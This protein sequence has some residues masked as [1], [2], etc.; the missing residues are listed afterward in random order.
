MK[1]ILAITAASGAIYARQIAERLVADS[2]VEQIDILFSRQ[3]QQVMNY[4]G[5]A[6][7]VSSKICYYDNDD[8]FAPMASGSSSYEA[9]IIAPCSA[10]TMCRIASGLSD[11]LITRAA[12]VM[13][14]EQRKLLLLLRESP[15]S[16]IH[17]NAMATLA[18]V[19][20]TIM[21]AAVSYY[22]HAQ[23][24]E[25]LALTISSRTVDMIGCQG[26]VRQ[27]VGKEKM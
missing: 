21:P 19:G 5:E 20:V 8:L 7:P 3:A 25:E 12:D 10:G 9:M 4:E 18:Q 13:I 2:N 23:S 15:L 27:W 14:K 11:T 24:V 1:I 22:H 17:I 6:L 16:L 26:D